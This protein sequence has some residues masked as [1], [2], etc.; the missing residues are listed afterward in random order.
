LAEILI[1]NGKRCIGVRYSEHGSAHGARDVVVSAG[2]IN[3]HSFWSCRA[4]AY[5]TRDS[6][7]VPD[8]VGHRA[9][10]VLKLAQ[11]DVGLA[12]LT[13]LLFPFLA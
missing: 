12:L 10:P 2:S 8:R 7:A 11:Q 1:L 9:E 6:N 13:A 3:S 4:G 5:K